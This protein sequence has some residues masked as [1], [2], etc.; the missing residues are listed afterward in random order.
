[1]TTPLARE[2]RILNRITAIPALLKVVSTL[3]GIRFVT[4]TRWDGA[5]WAACAIHDGAAV[6]L[7]GSGELDAVTAISTHVRATGAAGT[8]SVGDAGEYL[9][10]AEIACAACPDARASMASSSMSVRAAL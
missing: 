2:M 6:A 4:I 9:P 8:P 1:M 10:H 3:T 5:A 7:E